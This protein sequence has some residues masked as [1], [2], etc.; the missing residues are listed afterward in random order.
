MKLKGNKGEWSEIYALFK[1]LAD[2]K[3]YSGDVNLQ[4][5]S[6]VFFPILKIIRNETKN[7]NT[8]SIDEIKKQIQIAGTEKEFIV[9]QEIFEK[10]AQILFNHIVSSKAT[11]EEKS[12]SFPDIE[13]FMHSVLIHHVKA[14]SINKK[15]IRMII[16]D[17]RTDKTPEM[18]FSIKS[19]L[20]GN[21]TLVNSNKDGTNF[22]Y[23][24]MG[25]LSDEQIKQINQQKFFLSKF[26]LLESN[27]CSINYC[28]VVNNTFN[29]NLRYID[30]EIHTI[31]AWCLLGYYS[32]KTYSSKMT[33]VIAWVAEQNPCNYDKSCEMDFY[34]HKMKQFLLT[35]ALGMTANK[36]WNG[37]Y[38]ANGGYIVVKENGDIVCY[39]FYDRN[40]LEDYLFNNTMFDTPSKTR[41]LFGNIIKH[42]NDQLY[43]KLNILIRFIHNNNNQSKK[44]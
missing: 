39:H 30:S 44:Y 38:Q 23:K 14:K 43:L 35:Y 29:C 12:L 13:E 9:N 1:L 33:D 21:S 28:N 7:C 18:G 4:K 6:G 36:K 2:G 25:F 16:H 15:D 8:Y 10:Q 20:G 24:I 11:G 37:V 19:K 40:Q 34:E 41:H 31:L 42:E 32:H 3:L 27:N 26:K 17:F 5:I 22:L